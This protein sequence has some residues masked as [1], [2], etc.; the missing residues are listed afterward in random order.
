MLHFFTVHEKSILL[1][2]LPASFLAVEERDVF[3][4]LIYHGLLS[5]FPLLTRDKL[6][7][8]YVALY[9]LFV[10]LYHAPGGRKDAGV[11]NSIP[12]IL[13]SFVLACSLVLHIVY[14][15]VPPPDKYPFLFEALIMSLCFSQFVFIS[16]YT[17]LKQWAPSRLSS[18]VVTNKKSLWFS[19]ARLQNTYWAL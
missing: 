4:W 14:L 8:P 9:G 19:L 17:N 11:S 6:V 7:I 13:K 18:Q 16:I 10:L 15:T 3:Q 2:L 12:S 5:M 1:P